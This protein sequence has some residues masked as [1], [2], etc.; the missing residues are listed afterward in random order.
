MIRRPPR[1]TL[2]PY[3]TLFRS[4][5]AAPAGAGAG[6]RAGPGAGRPVARPPPRRDLV[7]AGP[8]PDP[9]HRGGRAPDRAE[10]LVR[11][12]I[13]SRVAGGRARRGYRRGQPGPGVPL[14]G[15]GRDRGR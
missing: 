6:S 15:L 10:V 11:H 1:S 9:G 2:F 14:A 8:A 7:R 4:L 13:E 3:T 12:V 5:L